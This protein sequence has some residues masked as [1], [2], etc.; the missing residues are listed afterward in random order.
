MK[1]AAIIMILALA[2]V[3]ITGCSSGTTENNNTGNQEQLNETAA[4]GETTQ[5][6]V[7][8]NDTVDFGDVI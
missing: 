1:L 3:V 4:L 8:D 6:I 5:G 2:L 7:N